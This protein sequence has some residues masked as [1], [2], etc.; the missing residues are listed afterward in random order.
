[1]T[2]GRPLFFAL[3]VLFALLPAK[4]G[5]E[6]TPSK[7]HVLVIHSYAPDFSWT[8]DMELGIDSVLRAPEVQASFRVEYMDAKHHGSPQY[9]AQLLQIYREKYAAEH[10]DGIILTDNHALDF[11]AQ[12]RAELFP[13]TPIAASGINDPR[14]IPANVDNMNI[15]IEIVS[16][17][18]TLEAALKQNPG[19]RKVYVVVDN[20]LTGRYIRDDFLAQTSA[21]SSRVE[22]VVLPLMTFDEL[23]RFAQARIKGE[24]IY[25]LV[26]FQDAAGK[27]LDADVVPR[28][29]AANSPVPV[30]VAWDFQLGLGPAGGCVASA[31]GHGRKAAQTLLERLAGGHPPPVYDKPLGVNIFKYDFAALQRFGIPLS[32][33]PEGSI[34]LNRPLSFYETHRVVLLSSLAIISVLG[35]IIALLLQNIARQRKINRGNAEILALNREMIETQLELLSTLGEVIETRSHE[36]ANHVKRVAAYS[37]LLAQKHGL[38]QDEVELLAAASPMHDIGKI[39]IP[40]AVL[41]KDGRLTPEEHNIIK[42]HTVIGHKILHTSERALMSRAC[43]IALQHHERW[44][45]GGYPCGLKGEEIDLTARIIAL[46]DVYDALSLDRVYK[47]AWPQ[48]K[49]LEFIQQQR[50]TMFDP[51]LVDLFFE[52]LDELNIIRENLSDPSVSEDHEASIAGPPRCPLHKA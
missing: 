24:L 34:I 29:V 41:N 16:H 49:V 33:L 51:K 26:Y 47:K 35:V 20:T 15:I 14:S 27:S 25:L 3:A 6:A 28:A 45:G 10:F 19:T 42:H 46:A 48:A 37:A 12:H 9:L 52:N 21:L 1:M 22:I 23:K 18:E 38:P 11:V 32:S 17:K 43:V 2:K 4:A 44:D 40:D 7:P 50:G 31:F 39:G 8:R 5:G 36:T 30:Y 13:K